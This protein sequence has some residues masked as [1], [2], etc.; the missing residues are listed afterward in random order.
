MR[1]T[2]LILSLA[3]VALSPAMSYVQLSDLKDR[4][5]D[6]ELIAALDDDR[7]GAVD[8]DVW[9][10]IQA[11]VQTEIDGILG[12]RFTVPFVDPLPAVVKLAAKRFALEA[13]YARRNLGGEKQPWVVDANSTRKTLLAI[14]AGDQPLAPEQKRTNPS[15][16][17]IT[18]PSRT[19][20][21]RPAI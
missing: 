17:V 16:S 7:D 14:A 19:H 21:D 2:I 8:S 15:V 20:S 5:P 18:E 9:A 11:G 1:C 13:V 3:A 6:R 12:Q 10:Q 4:I